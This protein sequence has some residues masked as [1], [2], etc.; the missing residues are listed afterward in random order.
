MATYPGLTKIGF[1]VAACIAAGCLVASPRAW[2]ACTGPAPLEARIRARPDADAYAELGA[3]F[4][5]HH[6]PQCALKAWSAALKLDPA[7]TAALDGEAKSMLAAS[8]YASTIRSL[9]GVAHDEALT[10]DLAIA[11]RKSG[12]LEEDEQTL[13]Q[14]LNTD[15]DSDALTAALVSLYVDESHFEAATTLAEKIAAD[16]P[17]DL[18]AQRIFLRTLVITGDNDRAIP[19]GH[20]LLVLAPHDADLLNLNG[21]LENKAG[22]YQTARKHLDEAVL[23]S[24]NDYNP[25]VNLG[26]VL[27]E[28]NEPAGAKIQ[29]EKA[30]ALGTDEAQVHFELGKVE[31]TLGETEAARQQFALYQQKLKQESDR[32]FAVSK[33]A[34]AAQAAKAGDNLKSAE[35]YREACSAEPQ[36]A[37]LAYQ[38]ALALDNLNDRAGERAALEQA[39]RANPHFILAH[40]QLGYVDFQAGD[41]A[42][43][44]RHFRLTVA[45]LP[46][47]AQAWIS[48]AAALA[49]Q[50]RFA[51]AQQAVAHALKLEPHNAAALSLSRRLAE[52]R[53]Q[54]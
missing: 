46:D 47:N 11:Y 9:K 38:L 31:R 15:P 26:M 44:E 48:L 54:H 7:S 42:A 20:K 13:K 34:E 1:M 22:D 4:D 50:S 36:D 32:A 52:S 8:D 3:W 19:L 29:L 16:K 53:K 49:A 21:L 24:P 33:A 6:Q 28:L 39:I 41:N 45:E 35:L 25:R 30:L 37:G 23:L 43:A 27:A 5:K 12:M 14:G 17:D 51:D 2:A 10:L 40:Y 18:E